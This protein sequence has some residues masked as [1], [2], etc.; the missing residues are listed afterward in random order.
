MLVEFSHFNV[1]SLKTSFDLFS[2][3]I[4]D[5]S[6]DVVGLSETWL[7]SD[8]SDTSFHIENYVLKRRDRSG[9][10]GGVA[11]YVKNTIKFKVIDDITGP[12]DVLEQ[13][14]ISLK[15][16][17]KRVCLGTVY[18]PPNSNLNECIQIL[19]NTLTNII[20]EYD[21]LAFGGDIK[22]DLTPDNR[23]NSTALFLIF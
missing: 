13:L 10:G 1:R 22:V 21:Y 18:R 17:G 8:I 9:R 5:L 7:S 4:E 11:F 12:N 2:A 19:E 3:A 6:L 20:P 14:W 15:C 23:N 16:N